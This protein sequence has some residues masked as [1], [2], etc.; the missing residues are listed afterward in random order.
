[1]RE[2]TRV[3]NGWLGHRLEHLLP[4]I[5]KREGFDMWIVCAREYNEDPV[6]MS[7]LPAPMLSARRRT[8]LV[9]SVQG[10]RFEALNVAPPGVGLDDYYRGVWNKGKEE[11]EREDQWACL[12]RIVAERDP[13]VIGINL[14]ETFAFG[15]GLSHTEHALLMKAL[16]P[17]YAE[18]CRGA[19]RL[20]VGWLE[21][22]SEGELQTA[23]GVN[24]IA[25]GVIAEAFSSRVVHPGVST[26]LDVAWWIRQRIQDL[27]LS[28]WFQ[29][30]VSIQRRGAN[31][32][33]IGAT[34]DEVIV[35][36]DLLHCDVGLHYLGLAT[37]TQRLAYVLRLGE[38]DAPEGLRKALATGN[39]LQDI[40][41]A[42]L[43]AGRMG[44]E[45]LAEALAVARGEGLQ[46]RIYSHPIGYHGHGAGPAIGMYDNQEG[47]PGRGDYPLFADTLHSFELYIK[48]AVPEWEGQEVKIALE[49]VVAFTGGE[50]HFLAGRQ[51]ALHLI[52]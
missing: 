33:D 10:G 47:V 4:E 19:E 32:G 37:D 6:L 27:G 40:L 11:L 5:M 43:V 29:P 49:Q 28:A 42:E 8:I 18:R 25:H 1:M 21:R 44:N 3:V 24:E 52:G 23:S 51:M 20:A 36:G 41:A 7:L 16:G 34:P 48:Q 12:Q 38:D 2:Q 13:T 14:S 22:R 46:A 45:I 39:R 35:P 9:F 50:V 31:V 15:D 17:A 26:A 30:T